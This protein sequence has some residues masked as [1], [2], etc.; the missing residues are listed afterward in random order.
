MTHPKASLL[1]GLLYTADTLFF[2]N[3]YMIYKLLKNAVVTIHYVTK[4]GMFEIQHLPIFGNNQE[5]YL[6]TV[7][8]EH[9]SRT[10]N[11]KI[12]PFVAYRNNSNGR[13][14]ITEGM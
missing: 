7:A 4:S 10:P 1:Y 6:E 8:P 13:K 5:K 12:D 14:Y 3:A 9:I 11:V 2:M